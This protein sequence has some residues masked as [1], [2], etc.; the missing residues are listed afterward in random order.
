MIFKVFAVGLTSLVLNTNLITSNQNE[1]N[2]AQRVEQLKSNKSK[3]APTNFADNSINDST[4]LIGGGDEF[5]IAFVDNPSIFY[6][7]VVN[8]NL[9]LF[10]PELGIVKIGKIPLLDAKIKI[11]E[12]L[13][14]KI[15]K[16]VYVSLN[17]IK[18]VTITVNGPVTH[19]GT[20]T[21]S[22]TMRILDMISTANDDTIPPI[23]NFN[24]RTVRCTNRG[25]T[26]FYDLYKYLFKGDLTQNPYIY[27]GDEIMIE[28]V[29]YNVFI[30]GDNLSLSGWVPIIPNESI[31]DFLDLFQFGFS[32]DLENVI[33]QRNTNSGPKKFNINFL[34]RENFILQNQDVVIV[35]R[36]ME[37]P[38]LT[39]VTVSG[40]A[41]RPGLFPIT[42]KNV[43]AGELIELAGGVSKHGDISRAV[44][45]RHS[46]NLP[47]ITISD[48]VRP[49][50]NS[51]FSLLNSKKDY[52]VIRLHD[53]NVTIEPEDQIYIPKIE[54]R[55]FI[56]G[57]V[58]NP[59][60]VPYE[61]G[62]SRSDYI[63]KA[64]G[65]QK[66]ADR[67]NMFVITQYD[68]VV[69][70]K[71]KAEIEEGDIIVVPASQQNKTISTLV[72]PII[73]AVATTLG[74]VLALITT[75]RK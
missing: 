52:S 4:Y 11:S 42:K 15:K 53:L 41:A 32:A 24:L 7:G 27:P 66:R 20:Y 30:S 38:D 50:I 18:T 55:V 56:S 19:P 44:I 43:T 39:V 26:Q 64:G 35:T 31:C 21:Q 25:V 47:E 33:V 63:K 70:T 14:K 57:E 3:I 74:V 1:S 60:A 40:E 71:D 73:S 37:F 54:D 51:A 22:G 29:D 8:Q 75:V 2:I 12:E 10:I 34:K 72:L 23:Q 46:K 16:K 36:K 48:A 6:T 17:K 49:E 69:I 5:L 68:D 67:Q 62:L 61:K 9:D 45:L 59:G 58:K 13:E 65:L 28:K